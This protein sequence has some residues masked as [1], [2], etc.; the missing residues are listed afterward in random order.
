MQKEEPVDE[1]V[2]GWQDIHVVAPGKEKKPA[3]QD[4]SSMGV[5]W[6]RACV[7]ARHVALHHLPAAVRGKLLTA[8]RTLHD[9]RTLHCRVPSVLL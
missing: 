5:G 9:I 6:V 8:S 1:K 4:C 2:P 7:R 3:G